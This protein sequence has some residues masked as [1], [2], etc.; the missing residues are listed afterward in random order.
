MWW[1]EKN[2]QM[3]DDYQRYAHGQWGFGDFLP[4]DWN[5]EGERRI[6]YETE[7]REFGVLYVKYWYVDNR[8][9]KI[10]HMWIVRRGRQ[11][12]IVEFYK[13]D[14]RVAKRVVRQRCFNYVP[15]EVIEIAKKL[16]YK[17]KTFNV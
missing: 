4:N 10:D 16:A 5:I 9:K 11:E 17:K 8:W 12:H 1:D 7:D 3:K 6:V 2:K 13:V 14:R 15:D